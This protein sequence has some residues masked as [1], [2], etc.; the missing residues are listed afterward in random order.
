MKESIIFFNSL[1][2]NSR[3]RFRSSTLKTLPTLKPRALHPRTFSFPRSGTLLRTFSNSRPIFTT[4]Q[5][6]TNPTLLDRTRK[7]CFLCVPPK[8][9]DCPCTQSDMFR[10]KLEYVRHALDGLYFLILGLSSALILSNGG[11]E[12]EG[13][14][15]LNAPTLPPEQNSKVK[16]NALPRAVVLAM[17]GILIVRKTLRLWYSMYR[18]KRLGYKIL[19]SFAE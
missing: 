8:S 18:R 2:S 4:E 11:P 14:A 5:N 9:L 10:E 3:N 12:G 15:M 13:K 6:Q 7:P 16:V 19:K 17:G 1:S